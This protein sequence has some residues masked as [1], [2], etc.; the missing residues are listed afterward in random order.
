MKNNN[1]YKTNHIKQ[2]KKIIPK[3]EIRVHTLSVEVPKNSRNISNN[4]NNMTNNQ[5][6]IINITNNNY[7]SPGKNKIFQ[8]IKLYKPIKQKYYIKKRNIS[9]FKKTN[10]IPFNILIDINISPKDK[11]SNKL[12]SYSNNNNL[13]N[14]NNTLSHHQKTFYSNSHNN[15]SSKK[16]LIKSKSNN[17]FSLPYK[18]YNCSRNKNINN[19]LKKSNSNSEFTKYSFDSNNI[20][21]KRN[22]SYSGKNYIIIH[23]KEKKL[24]DTKR[25]VE[26]ENDDDNIKIQNLIKERDEKLKEIINQNN[27]IKEQEKLIQGLNKN[28]NEINKKIN[29]INNDYKNLKNNYN[30]IINESKSL[31]NKLINNE[32]EIISMQEKEIKLLK[33]LYLIKKKGIDINEILNKNDIKLNKESNNNDENS[34]LNSSNITSYFPDKVKMKNIMETKE[35]KKIPKIDFKLIPEYSF[36][37]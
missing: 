35:A 19:F 21:K 18:K 2:Y 17:I 25:K 6:Q 23:E 3:N 1:L 33:V 4:Y 7:N 15:N 37:D 16:L 20:Y 31:K 5:K 11:F 26:N 13:N 10:K 22:A 36:H 29:N 28:E 32:K 30:N 27:I 9:S 12:I 24:T 34:S 14:F 8:N